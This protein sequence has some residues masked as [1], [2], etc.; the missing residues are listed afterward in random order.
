L[1]S[2]L[3]G[4]ARDTLFAHFGSTLLPPINNNASATEISKWKKLPE[5]A[6]CYNKLFNEKN[7]SALLAK[8][9]EKVLGKDPPTNHMAFVMALYSVMLDPNSEGIHA[10]ENSMKKK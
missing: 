4:R 8:I 1:R 10:N 5:V 2:V 6:A 7:D 3:A 9:L